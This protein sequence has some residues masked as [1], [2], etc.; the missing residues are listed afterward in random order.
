ME[1]FAMRALLNP[2]LPRFELP[3]LAVE[4]TLLSPTLDLA[5]ISPILAPLS[6]AFE[7]HP[8]LIGTG[9]AM[10]GL[11]ATTYLERRF[12]GIFS[13]MRVGDQIMRDL[14]FAT[15]LMVTATGISVA[16]DPTNLPVELV[17]G[18][19]GLSLAIF[20]LAYRTNKYG[21]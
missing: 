13:E 2:F 17:A 21:F 7:R 6:E 12:A 8:I 16:T 9:L 3:D 4:P 1:E 18:F 10:A 5:A 19:Y 20:A 11:Q 14:F 15:S